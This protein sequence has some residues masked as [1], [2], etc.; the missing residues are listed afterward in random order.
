ML[1]DTDTDNYPVSQIGMGSAQV[2]VCGVV[3]FVCDFGFSSRTFFLIHS[4]P[5][6]FKITVKSTIISI[7]S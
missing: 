3:R 1:E 6:R 4:I 7:F 2:F 5:K